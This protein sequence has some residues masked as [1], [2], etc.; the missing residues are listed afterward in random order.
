M[1]QNTAHTA[2]VIGRDLFISTRHA[3][4]ITRCIRGKNLRKSK[5]LLQ[6]VLDKKEAV[7]F[8]RHDQDIPHRPGRIMAGRY[9]EKATKMIL[10]LL[11]SVEANA[12]NNGLDTENLV[13]KSII[14][15]RASRP[16]RSGRIRGIRT[17]STHIEVVVEEKETKKERQPQKKQQTQQKEVKQEQNKVSKEGVKK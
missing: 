6:R 1:E 15:N 2:R 7:P 4:E 16:Y 12:Q 8:L 11:N 14:P 5:A 10:S 13:I 3:I 9:P 17:R